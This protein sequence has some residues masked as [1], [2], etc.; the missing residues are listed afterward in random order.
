M[1]C[2]VYWLGWLGVPLLNR[3]IW[4]S[5]VDSVVC[6]WLVHIL[7]RGFEA[8]AKDWPASLDHLLNARLDIWSFRIWIWRIDCVDHQVT[9]PAAYRHKILARSN[10]LHLDVGYWIWELDWNLYLMLFVA[11]IFSSLSECS[12]ERPSLS[13]K[14]SHWLSNARRLRSAK[15]LSLPSK[16]L[17][18]SSEP[19]R[20]SSSESSTEGRLLLRLTAPELEP[21]LILTK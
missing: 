5:N 18:L 3:T 6:V 13:S 1:L 19:L 16:S 20:L 21:T 11:L 4:M 8:N 17:I 10:L 9:V 12:P 15:S 2:N 7:G 14:T